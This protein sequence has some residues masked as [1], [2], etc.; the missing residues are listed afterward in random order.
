MAL[1]R[2]ISKKYFKVPDNVLQQVPAGWPKYKKILRICLLSY[3]VYS[4]IRLHLLVDDS[5]F[6]YITK[7]EKFIIIIIYL[8]IIF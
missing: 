7:L 4:Q 5:Q 3:L 6:G 2:Q 1:I 8:F